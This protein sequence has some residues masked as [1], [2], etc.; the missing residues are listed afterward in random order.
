MLAGL[1]LL[2]AEHLERRV[3]DVTVRYVKLLGPKRKALLH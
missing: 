3:Q 1:G 2:D